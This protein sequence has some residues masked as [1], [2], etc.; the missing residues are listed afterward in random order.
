[1]ILGFKEDVTEVT[2]SAISGNSTA[3]F[4]S[5]PTGISFFQIYSDSLTDAV[6][7]KANALTGSGFND[8]RLIL[9]GSGVS[10]VGGS[11]VVR[12]SQGIADLDQFGDD[13]NLND[14][15][16]QKTVQGSGESGDFSITNLTTDPL[17]F[18]SSLTSMGFTFVN[19]APSLP[20][21]TV[22]PSDCF[23][24]SANAVAVGSV[25]AASGCTTAHT[26]GLYSANTG[27]PAPGYVPNI[28][29]VN[30]QLPI[31]ATTGGPDFVSQVDYNAGLAFA[32][33]EPTSLALLGLGFAA[34][35][36]GSRRRRT[37]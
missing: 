22:D 3:S 9:S 26:D 33:P 7:L 35:G 4:S 34:L 25:V 2:T 21:K 1:M 27:E 30:G 5:V 11:F 20:F 18:L 14:F 10:D 6:G 31:G 28:G 13:G 16:G 23:T 24:V 32:V 29:A 36:V 17:Y 15:D 12:P 8:G 37:A 19:I